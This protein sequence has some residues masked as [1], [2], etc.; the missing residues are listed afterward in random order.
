M[1]L[2]QVSRANHIAATK[3]SM[4][5][6]CRM[7][8]ALAKGM[9]IRVELAEKQVVMVRNDSRRIRA[10]GEGGVVN[11]SSNLL[12]AKQAHVRAD[13]GFD[14]VRLPF[15][16]RGG[17]AIE[18]NCERAIWVLDHLNGLIAGG[19]GHQDLGR[20]RDFANWMSGHV[21]HVAPLPENLTQHIRCRQRLKSLA[22][23]SCSIKRHWVWQYRV[24]QPGYAEGSKLN[25]PCSR[26]MILHSNATYALFWL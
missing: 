8:Y 2:E 18:R 6:S 21:V 26:P 17:D 9:P 22:Q 10:Q 4:A 13:A 15:V 25:L 11:R 14:L 20:R 19:G 1:M 7:P 24:I 5:R 12:S 23:T 3:V 16:M